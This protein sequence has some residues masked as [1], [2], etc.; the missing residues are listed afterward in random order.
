MNY[1][2][3]ARS[4]RQT[5]GEGWNLANRLL[6]LFC[7]LRSRF[8]G[9]RRFARSSTP[10][11]RAVGFHQPDA[12]SELGVVVVPMMAFVI[13]AAIV[14]HAFQNVR[15]RVTGLVIPVEVCQFHV[16]LLQRRYQVVI[17]AAFN[18]DANF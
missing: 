12:C 16:F 10:C 5:L 3:T 4:Q 9:K 13:R 8:L 15:S 14:E 2:G 7:E 1:N 17:E 6:Y 11:N 18:V